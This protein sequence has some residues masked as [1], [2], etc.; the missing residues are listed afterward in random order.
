MFLFIIPFTKSF[1]SSGGGSGP[2]RNIPS[3]WNPSH[4]HSCPRVMVHGERDDGV[5][6]T[7]PDVLDLENA[8]K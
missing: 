6:V 1:K 2:V 8:G 7:M 4:T 5:F 3:T